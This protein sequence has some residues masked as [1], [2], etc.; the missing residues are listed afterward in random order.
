MYLQRCAAGA[1]LWLT[2]ATPRHAA[3]RSQ[4][5]GEVRREVKSADRSKGECGHEFRQRLVALT[6][7]WEVTRC[8]VVGAESA[9]A[10]AQMSLQKP[11]SEWHRAYKAK[12]NNDPMR[13][14]FS[15]SSSHTR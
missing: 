5:K 13:R 10:D 6:C 15:V 4:I 12:A 7:L 3:E 8:V 2:G 14:Q 1:A 9:Y 11:R